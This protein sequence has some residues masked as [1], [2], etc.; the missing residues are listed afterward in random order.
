MMMGYDHMILIILG[1]L[2]DMEMGLGL[3]SIAFVYVLIPKGVQMRYI[4]T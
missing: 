4:R 2:L 1:H 3:R